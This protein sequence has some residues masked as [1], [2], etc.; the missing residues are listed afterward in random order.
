M[1]LAA[2]DFFSRSPGCISPG[3]DDAFFSA[4]RQGNQTFKRTWSGRFAGV[5]QRLVTLLKENE[6]RIDRVL[7]I[8]M[9]SGITTLELQQALG[10]AGFSPRITGTDL[11]VS[12]YIVDLGS[13]CR[14]LVGEDG[15]PLQ[16]EIL[17]LT[18]RP[19]RRKLDLVNGMW[20][21][22]P[23]M[24]QTLG[25]E[26][27][28]RFLEEGTAAHQRVQLVSPRIRS[29]G[30]EVVEDN[31]LERR[32]ELEGRFDLVRAANIL[33]KSYFSDDDLRRALANVGSYLKGPGSWLLLAR[34]LGDQSQHGSLLRVA[35]DGRS[36]EVMDRFG[37]GAEVEAIALDAFAGASP[38]A[39][40]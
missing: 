11:S 26:A 18:A 23:A 5:N 9:S 20:I 22:K 34:T 24:H 6:A 29:S 30:I 27:T 16:Y 32:A 40:Q 8:G 3:Q 14:V 15:H 37:E 1:I 7:D 33:I 21:A 35:A 31:I 4:I 17:G 28:R 25:R 2:K 13:G 36:L 38:T 39:G 10:A 12:A 19:W